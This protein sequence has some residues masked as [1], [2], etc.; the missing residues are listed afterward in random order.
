MLRALD[1]DIL[2]FFYMGLVTET[3]KFRVQ[4]RMRYMWAGYIY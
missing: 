3:D 2:F 4:G 1:F